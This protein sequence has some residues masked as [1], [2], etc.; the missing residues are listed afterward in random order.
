MSAAILRPLALAAAALAAAP[1]AARDAAPASEIVHLDQGLTAEERQRF[2]HLSVGS[3]L[4]PLSVLRALK[5]PDTGEP[6]LAD[7]ERFGM[8]A[9]PD[10]PDG[11]PIGLSVERGVGSSVLGPIA[12]INCAACHVTE[13]RHE[14]K[15]V[16]VDGSAGLMDFEAFSAE[17]SKALSALESASA[18]ASFVGRIVTQPSPTAEPMTPLTPE[19]LTGVAGP[20][21]QEEPESLS[22]SLGAGISGWTEGLSQTNRL[23]KGKLDF[24]GRMG[25]ME[26]AQPTGPGRTDD[27]VIARNLL[28]PK[29][30][31]LPRGVANA[32]YPALWGYAGYEWLTWNGATRS[33][34]ERG[35]ATVMGLGAL[36]DDAYES[37]VS[38]AAIVEHDRLAAKITPPAWPE[39]AL[40]PIDRDAAARGA[41]IYAARCAECHDA[42]G[43]YD[44]AEIGTDSTHAE[45]WAIPLGATEWE[46]EFSRSGQPAFADAFSAEVAKFTAEAWAQE[47]WSAEQI[48][49]A[50]PPADEVW[51]PVLQVVS[52]PLAG[53]W[54]TAPYLV[55]GSVPTIDALLRPVAERPAA[56]PVGHFDYDPAR[57]GYRTDI[58]RDEA[59]FWFDTTLEGNAN[60]GHLYGTDLSESDRRALIEYLK[61]L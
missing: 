46:G 49:A 19:A 27:W 12:G 47:G 38:P 52:R 10:H 11:L 39:D 58:P 59:V 28:F 37:T 1:T 42:P 15:A 20:P 32:S 23:F 17:L 50:V 8:L 54:A 4:L 16:R 25:E 48:A 6:F 7:P 2:Y 33:G 30:D 5:N 51:R 18:L 43:H 31:W 35:V 40:G 22:A 36:Y 41:E 29:E 57:L 9:N 3:Q 24:L 14:G 53:V 44:H 45:S 61:T 34:M 55:N 56:F 21:P 26:A 13:L 60:A